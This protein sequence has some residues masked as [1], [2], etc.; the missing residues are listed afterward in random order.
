MTTTTEL[1]ENQIKHRERRD[2]LKGLSKIAKLTISMG[3]EEKT[4]NAVLI[5]MYTDE[6]NT[7]FNTIHQWNDK[8]YR[9]KKGSES[10]LIWGKP[11]AKQKAESQQQPQDEEEV[12]FYPLCYLF[13]NA[14]V[15]K[16]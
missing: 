4:V 12:D 15:E 3:A 1:T 11:T 5:E 10:F 6:K 2:K 7:E 9:V 14:Q 8:G 13:S 16:R